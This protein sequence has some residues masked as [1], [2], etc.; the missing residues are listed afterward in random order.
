MSNHTGTYGGDEILALVLDP[1]SSTTHCGYAGEDTPKVVVG[2]DYG[3]VGETK[4]FG[5][6]KVNAARSGMEV[7]NPMGD[8]C[9]K[10]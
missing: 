6:V 8:G 5:D 7:M 1:G 2:S 3:R 10:L 9:G 4:V